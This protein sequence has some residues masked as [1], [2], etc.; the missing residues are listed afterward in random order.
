MS[1]YQW[2]IIAMCAAVVFL[3]GFDAQGISYVAP[4]LIKA[5]RLMPAQ[6][7]P[8]FS[9]GLIGLMLGALFIAPLADRVGRRPLI[10]AA[11]TVFGLFSLAT[12][13]GPR[14]RPAPGAALPDRPGPGRLHAPTPSP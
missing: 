7:G 8:V 5:W 10:L 9:I 11:T 13:W 2:S 14:H 1:P 3:D 12:A 4:R 6:L